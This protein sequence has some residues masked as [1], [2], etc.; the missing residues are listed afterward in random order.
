[1]LQT[2]VLRFVAPDVFPD[3][4][5]VTPNS[6]DEKSASSEALANVISFPLSVYAGDVDGT[7]SLIKPT[8]CDT[9]YFGGIE[10]NMCTW[11]GCRWPSLNPTFLLRT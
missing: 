8:T 6:G 4:G 3:H 9:A 10:I 5:F 11:S 1:M 7:L 2:V